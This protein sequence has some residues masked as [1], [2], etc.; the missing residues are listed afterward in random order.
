[1][2]DAV[3]D[4]FTIPEAARV[5]RVG[6]T[7]AYLLAKRHLVAG[8]RD[9]LPVVRVGRLLRVPRAELE[10]LVGG[11]ITWPPPDRDAPTVTRVAHTGPDVQAPRRGD[12]RRRNAA[13]LTLLESD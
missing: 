11:P 13:Q 2:T 8:D 5:L 3:P 9:G 1:V 7:A 4:F 10:R 6:R 12:A